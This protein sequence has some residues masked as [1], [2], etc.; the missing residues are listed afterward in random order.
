M[1]A[2]AAF[3]GLAR[4]PY[5]ALLFF[6]VVLWTPGIL[7]LPALDRDE[8]R[9]AQASRQMLESG[10]FIDIRFGTEPRYK[11]PVGIY[12]L[13][14][15]TTAAAGLGR[16]DRIWTYR[17]ASLAGGV[18]AVWL[19]FWC[20]LAITGA[21]G[22]LAAGALMAASLL[23]TAE[24]TIATTDSVLLAAVIGVEG[25]WLRVYR[26]ARVPAA[27]MPST[28][29]LIAGWVS[30]ATGI[31]LKGPV[32]P[33]VAAVT[34]LAL[35]AW[36]RWELR[37]TSSSQ[38]SWFWLLRLKPVLGVL[39]TL[40][41]VVPWLVAIARASH[42]AFFSQSLGGDFASKLAGGQESHFAPPGYY[43]LLV[44]L[45]FWPGIL[46]V[47]P[48]IG[49]AWS[50]RGEPAIRFL[51]AWAGASWAMFE[52]VPTKLPHYVLP[53]YPALAILAALWLCGEADAP[54]WPRA[55]RIVAGVSSC[56][57][58]FYSRR[59]PSCC[60]G[61]M[62]RAGSGGSWRLPTWAR[63]SQSQRCSSSSGMRAARLV[64]SRFLP[65]W[66]SCQRSLLASVPVSTDCGSAKGLRHWSGRMSVRP[67][68]RRQRP[69]MRSRAFC[70][71]LMPV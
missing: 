37:R 36:D 52:I 69:A 62:A 12:W 25:V 28:T 27:A 18:A 40:V 32:L 38:S 57:A 26:A 13:Q 51:L 15:A 48:G 22:A 63:C 11:K 7:S 17:L 14:A 6:C 60:R 71:R 61:F 45:S 50:R 20:A 21:E 46:F 42:G 3:A 67:T 47:A 56:S 44:A 10:N 41:L 5:A 70:S 1:S 66:Y 54:R 34:I 64:C 59:H 29:S 58:S 19:T 65:C 33:G 53:L 2:G 16:T 30:F 55:L 68:R 4:R 31:L 49:L 23:L 43:L 9:F 35:V 39:V 24:A 8:S